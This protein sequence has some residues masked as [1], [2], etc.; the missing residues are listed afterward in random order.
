VSTIL[1]LCKDIPV[2]TL[3]PGA[4][5]LT[6]GKKS[7]L[8]FVLI[9]GEVEILK[10]DMQVSTVSETGAIFGEMS[11]LLNLA[12]SATVRARTPCRAH[13]IENG[14]AFLQSNREFAYDLCKLLAQRLHGVTT[15][16]A[17]LNR[18]V[19]SM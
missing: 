5:L 17:D 14:D 8:L 2:Q 19:R 9:D 1:D 13:V 10:G 6:E 18:Y 15:Y 16:L 12:H 11:V 4:V 3:E 7:G